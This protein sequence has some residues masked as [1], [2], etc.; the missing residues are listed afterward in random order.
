MAQNVADNTNSC[1]SKD[2]TILEP[3]YYISRTPG[4]DVR[5]ILVDAFQVREV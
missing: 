5:G 3:Y 4:K 1:H 2:D